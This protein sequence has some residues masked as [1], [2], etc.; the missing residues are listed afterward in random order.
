MRSCPLHPE[1]G[2][3]FYRWGTYPRT[4]P[5]E[6]EVARYYCRRGGVTFSLVPDCLAAR[7]PGTLEQVEQAAAGVQRA[8]QQGGS[9]E[10]QAE[11]LRPPSES[12]DAVEPRSAV[13]W[14][15]RRHRAVVAGLVALIAVMPEVFG[16]CDATLEAVGE[17]VDDSNGVLLALRRAAG[18]NVGEIPGP[19][20]FLSR[21]QVANKGCDI[22]GQGA[23]VSS[24]HGAKSSAEQGA[25]PWTKRLEP[26][27][28]SPM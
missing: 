10:Q 18:E 16:G 3:G 20:G 21:R 13:A 2:C 4:V 5:I 6:S 25:E 24:F 11:A 1:G 12:P 19:I 26:R 7:M 9:L 27:Q 14:M 28:R 23:V 8:R 22:A 17:R 15:K